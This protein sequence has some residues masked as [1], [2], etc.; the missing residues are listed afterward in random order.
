MRRVI[1]LYN[2]LSTSLYIHT[3]T[4]TR[5]Y[6]HTQRKRERERETHAQIYIY[7]Y[8]YIFF[9]SIFL[10]SKFQHISKQELDH[11]RGPRWWGTRCPKIF[12]SFKVLNQLENLTLVCKW[13]EIELPS[14]FCLNNLKRLNFV[15]CLLPHRLTYNFAIADWMYQNIN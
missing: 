4:E 8:I 14:V 9:T 7:I 13:V 15:I 10:I 5:T 2:H 3:H 12:V 6:T 1:A 11:Y